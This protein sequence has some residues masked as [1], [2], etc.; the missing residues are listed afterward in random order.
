MKNPEEKRLGLYLH[1]PFCLSKC[2]YCD[3]CSFPIADI[4]TAGKYCEALMRD[5]TEYGERLSAY[6]VDT[7][8]F[9]GGT[10][11]FLPPEQLSALLSHAA[12]QFH[13]ASNI[14]IT[15][16]CNPA[17]ISREGLAHLKQSGF[18][19]LSIGAQSMNDIEL[20][21]L[22]RRHTAADTRRIC[23]EAKSVGFDNLSLDLMFGIPHMTRE[24][25][26]HTLHEV[27]DIAP[28][29]LSL[30]GLQIEEGTPFWR[31][32]SS[33]PLPSEEEERAMYFESIELLAAHGYGQY[34]ISNFAKSGYASR[35]NLRYWRRED[36]LGL[37]LSAASCLGNE[38]FTMCDSLEAYLSGTRI[39]E[40]ETVSP[41]DALCESVMLGMRLTKGCDFD[42]LAVRYGEDARLYEARLA[43]YRPEGLVKKTT[44]GYAFTREGLCLSNSVLSD[45]LD[46]DGSAE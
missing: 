2:R 33:L 21:A 20:A 17:T 34:E 42:L 41:H 39:I 6:T 5:M 44:H 11:T 16:E 37:G 31:E 28:R 29:H 26:A 45:I 19:R 40:R 38:R 7:L 1:I 22:G 4:A 43:S 27:F 23:E 18:N 9:G 25:L 8:F 36:Y 12:R 14:E 3:F 24:S 35:H 13:F 32:R 30:Y 10:P 46:F 15:T